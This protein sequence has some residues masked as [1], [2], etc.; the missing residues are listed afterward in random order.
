MVGLFGT[1]LPSRYVPVLLRYSQ[2]GA[3]KS[4]RW[5]ILPIMWFSV[6]VA[7]LVVGFM[8]RLYVNVSSS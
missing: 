2:K 7:V 8:V 4:S 6:R 5:F 1:R 3:V